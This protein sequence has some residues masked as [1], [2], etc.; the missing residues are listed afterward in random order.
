MFK[1]WVACVLVGFSTLIGG[2]TAVFLGY[3]LGGAVTTACSTILLFIHRVC[4]KREEYYRALAEK[5]Q[6]HL[7]YGNQWLLTIQSIDAMPDSE[8]KKQRQARLVEVM[9]EK[10]L[11]K[12][13]DD[14]PR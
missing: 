12:P 13:Q 10:L 4:Q 8:M 11:G 6:R 14:G 7:E 2:I 1:L 3:D 9:T 5:K